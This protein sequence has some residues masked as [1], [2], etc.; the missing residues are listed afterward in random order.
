[1]GSGSY[2][3][4]HRELRHSFSRS[5]ILVNMCWP[6]GQHWVALLSHISAKNGFWPHVKKC[7]FVYIQGPGCVY[8]IWGHYIIG[9][10]SSNIVWTF[11]HVLEPYEHPNTK[12]SEKYFFGP[13]NRQNLPVFGTKNM[14]LLQIWCWDDRMVPMC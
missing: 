2:K 14:N 5:E 8:M 10:G 13:K 11:F 7:F 12:I 6:F 3:N 4:S 1:M 9:N